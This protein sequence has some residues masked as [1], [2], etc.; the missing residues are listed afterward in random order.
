MARVYEAVVLL[1]L[2]TLLVLGIVWVASALLHDNL[3][4]KSLYG[5]EDALKMPQWNILMVFGFNTKAQSVLLWIPDLWEYYLPYLYSG[6]SLFGVLLLLCEYIGILMTCSHRA[7]FRCL[8]QPSVFPLSV[9]SLWLVPDVQRDWEPTG[10]T[11]GVWRSPAF[12]FKSM[13]CGC[14]CRFHPDICCHLQL[15]EDV[16]ETLS[17]AVF[18][19]DYLLRKL[20]CE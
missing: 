11:A 8:Q 15:L 5:E 16:E 19:E 6:I 2:L 18:E 13:F 3:A 14:E 20:N 9:H 4:R 1:L 17:C 10:Q 7:Y 12:A